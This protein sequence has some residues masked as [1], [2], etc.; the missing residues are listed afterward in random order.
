MKTPKAGSGNGIRG[1]RLQGKT[2]CEFFAGIGLVRDGLS[3]SGWT[4][5]FANDID[6]KKQE[7]Y[8][9][10]FGD[11]DHFHLGDVWETQEI[12]SRIPGSPFLA[13][14]SFPCIDLSLAGHWRGFDGDHSSS[15]FGFTNALA[16]LGARRPMMILLENVTG[17]ITSHEGKD[18]AAAATAWPSL[19]TGWTRSSSMPSILCRKAAPVF[20]SSECMKASKLPL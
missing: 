5:V 14:A 15:F 4:C 2:F 11:S 8:E 20:L 10:H 12:V 13:T 16:Q 7:L 18:F 6:P 17:F 19:G 1:K 9:G 3:R